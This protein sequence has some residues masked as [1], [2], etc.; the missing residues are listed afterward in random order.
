MQF[1]FFERT[2]LMIVLAGGCLLYASTPVVAAPFLA[3]GFQTTDLSSVTTNAAGVAYSPD[4][5]LYIVEGS[6]NSPSHTI[7][8]VHSD[9]SLGTP[10]QVQDTSDFGGFGSV[11]G[12]TW[13]PITG[14]LLIT[15][16]DGGD[17]LF[18][19]PVTGS[20][21]S[22]HV[23]VTPSTIL[24]DPGFSVVPFISQVA[25]RPN[26]DIFV[27][28]AAGGP[29][30]QGPGASIYEINRSTGAANPVINTGQ[31][32]TA[33]MG[34]DSQGHL[35]Y[36][37]GAFNFSGGPPTSSIFQ[38]TLSGTGD[39][40]ATSGSPQLLTS[41]VGSFDLAVTSGDH[42]LVT[43]SVP[44]STDSGANPYTF[45]LFQPGLGSNAAD[46]ILSLPTASGSEFGESLAY[47]PGTTDFAPFS[48]AAGG[49]V[50][51]VLSQS[52]PGAGF[53]DTV[54]V[55]QPV[56]EPAT[57]ALAAVALVLVAAGIKLR[58]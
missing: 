36:Q 43:G 6:F 56:P 28:D 4:G 16:S 49:R 35:I 13:D 18:S 54:M 50:A 46:G 17:Y 8:V 39:A 22:G 42:L 19:V 25:V 15:D 3:P 33:G 38:V 44:V 27:S 30:I 23:N 24:S 32:Y 7:D 45:G 34:F 53:S 52:G 51:F 20:I 14:G 29:G 48:G 40:T 31:D 57:A 55:V 10:I 2:C 37:T 41:N 21:S 1:D 47:L 26:G 9:G 11:G 12:V 58:R 5:T